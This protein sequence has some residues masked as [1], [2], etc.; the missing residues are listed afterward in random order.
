MSVARSWTVALATL[1]VAAAGCTLLS[2]RHDPSRF[3]TLS[4]RVPAAPVGRGEPLSVVVG[5][6]TLPA[7]LDRN[8]V[9]V[10]VSASELK[11]ALAERWAEPLVQNVTRVLVE[12]L[13][14]ALASDRIASLATAPTATPDFWLEVVFVR[15]EADAAGNA[16]LTARWAVRDTGRRILRIRQSQHA[17]RAGAPTTEGGVDAMSAALGDLAEEMAGVL[18]ELAA[19]RRAPR[20]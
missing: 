17:G 15:F 6:V 7:Y 8:E 10:R 18:Q 13:G 11:Y 20:V 16:Q 19:E 14:N 3:Y 1:A 2:P 12:D 9:A 5:A 4:A